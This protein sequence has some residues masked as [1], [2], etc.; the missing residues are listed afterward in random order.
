MI[1]TTAL[2]LHRSCRFTIYGVKNK[3]IYKI[4]RK[5]LEIVSEIC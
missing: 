1:E 3:K 4:L 5:T 2:D